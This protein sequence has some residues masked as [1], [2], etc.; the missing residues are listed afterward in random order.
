MSYHARFSPG[1]MVLI[2]AGGVYEHYGA[3]ISRTYPVN[4]K[5]T[6]AQAEL[7][8]AV[9]AVQTRVIQVSAKTKTAD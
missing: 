9:L 4:R 2:D 1:E 6:A 7:Y 8:N 3:D 5:F